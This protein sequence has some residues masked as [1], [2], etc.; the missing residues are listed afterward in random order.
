M[1]DGKFD[2]VQAVRQPRQVLSAVERHTVVDRDDFVDAVGEQKTPV[3][4]RNPR[5]AE[6][7]KAAV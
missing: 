4:R 7:Q 5:L 1:F 2:G 3:Q 6:R